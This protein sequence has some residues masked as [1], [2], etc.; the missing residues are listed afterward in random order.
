[1]TSGEH[2]SFLSAPIDVTWDVTCRC[3]LACRHCYADSGGDG[4]REPADELKTKEAKVLIDQ[5]GKMGVFAVHFLGGEPLLREDFLGL[6]RRCRKRNVAAS[7]GTNGW[8]VDRQLATRLK[9][10]AVSCVNVSI[11]GATAATHDWIR[12]KPG[13]FARATAAVRHLADAGIAK[14]AVLQTVM[15]KNVGETAALIDLAADLGAYAFHAIPLTPSGRGASLSRQMGL[16]PSDV[17]ALRQALLER[18]RSLA[19]RIAVSASPGVAESPESRCV[20]ETGAVPDFM[21]CKAARLTC[22]IDANGDVFACPVVKGPV[23]GNVRDQ[24][25]REIWDHSPVFERLRRVRNDLEDCAACRFKYVC[26]REC[27]LSTTQRTVDAACRKQ[28]VES[29]RHACSR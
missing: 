23:A 27:P 16:S 8:C 7:F 14:V 29:H 26:A 13:S 22:S 28:N 2:V 9:K 24:P 12:R 17:S 18:G 25:L 5:L 11:D 1:M 19:D 4:R 20:R 21:G 15:K 10:A 3:N 6:L